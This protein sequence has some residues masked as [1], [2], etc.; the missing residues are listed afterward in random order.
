MKEDLS[1][2]DEHK[3]P[4]QEEKSDYDK[5]AEK[6]DSSSKGDSDFKSPAA[7]ALKHE[8][9]MREEEEEDKKPTEGYM[10]QMIEDGKDELQK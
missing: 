4:E 6:A 9:K 10:K 2:K 7:E 8:K 3:E 5:E 1:A